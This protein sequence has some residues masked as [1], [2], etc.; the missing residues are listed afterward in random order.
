MRIQRA[1]PLNEFLA[2]LIFLILPTA[3]VGYF[4]LD[5]INQY[6]AILQNQAF[7]QTL[8]LAGGMG[9]AA[10]VYSFRFRFVP[11]AAIVILVLYAM[12]KGLTV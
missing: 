11:T 1:T 7:Q 4:L 5:N 9:I 10:L 3:A 6:Y 8:Y 2:R 12:Y